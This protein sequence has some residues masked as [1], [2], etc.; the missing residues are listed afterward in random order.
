M[1]RML[2]ILFSIALLNLSILLLQ[3]TLK[4]SS[5]THSPFTSYGVTVICSGLLIA[6]ITAG[7]LFWHERYRANGRLF[8]LF[9][10]VCLAAALIGFS[11]NLCVV[12]FNAFKVA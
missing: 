3:S 4:Q 6:G 9:N 5:D 2:T 7:V 1:S 11:A 8:S 12:A 10:R